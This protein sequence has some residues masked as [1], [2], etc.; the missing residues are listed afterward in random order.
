MSVAKHW[1]PSTP[2]SMRAPPLFEDMHT[3]QEA[4]S[5][6]AG[7]RYRVYT[8]LLY[9]IHPTLYSAVT[10]LYLTTHI[11]MQAAAVSSERGVSLAGGPLHDA[12]QR[13]PL[14][15]LAPASCLTNWQQEFSRWGVH[16]M[17]FSITPKLCIESLIC[18]STA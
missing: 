15:V 1:R 11:L 9:P 3:L 5:P 10:S 16:A 8:Y 18:A 17:S 2:Y 13:G 6:V 4:S 14:L 12:A 7:T